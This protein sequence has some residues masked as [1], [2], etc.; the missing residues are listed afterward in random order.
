[1]NYLSG[2]EEGMEKTRSEYVFEQFCQE[3]ALR[4]DRVETDN[5]STTPDY[6]VFPQE[7]HVVFEIKELQ[8]NDND[9]AARDEARTNGAAAAFADPRNRIRQK[10]GTAVKQL[11]RRS[12]GLHPAVLVLFDNGTFGGIDATDIKNAM[13]GDETVVVT[14]SAAGDRCIASRL[15]GGRKCTATDNR[16][17]SA[18][19]LL[20]T[21]GGVASLSIFHNVFARCPLPPSWFIGARCHQYSI[22]LDCGSGL[23][24]WHTV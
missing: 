13:Y 17:L 14:R 16:T 2:L 11:K 20:S 4:L 15:G 18:V 9:A 21:T 3:N 8:A 1:V 24:Q 23:P 22:D 7:H 19:A 12:E 10:I 5:D 6:D